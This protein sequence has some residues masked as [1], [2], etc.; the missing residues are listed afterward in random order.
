MEDGSVR[1]NG[2]WKYSPEGRNVANDHELESAL[3]KMKTQ[4]RKC[5]AVQ[6]A[7][8]EPMSVLVGS[9]L[10]IVDKQFFLSLVTDSLWTVKFDADGKVLKRHEHEDD[11]DHRDTKRVRF[12]H[13]QPV[14]R[15]ELETTNDTVSKRAKVE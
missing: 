6:R 13:K 11:D 7:S 2:S 15:A 8:M 3:A 5:K 14:N 9:T 1:Y 12:T 4:N 10:L